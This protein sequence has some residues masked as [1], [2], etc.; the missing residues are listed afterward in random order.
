MSAEAAAS[1]LRTHLRSSLALD[2]SECD[3]EESGQPPATCGNRYVAIRISPVFP[4]D[5]PENAF[6]EVYLA[7]ITVTVRAG[8]V[9]ADYHGTELLH[10]GKPALFQLCRQIATEI[11]NNRYDIMGLMNELLDVNSQP[12]IEP[13]DWEG[14]SQDPEP[15]GPEWFGSSTEDES[16]TDRNPAGYK[17][18]LRFGGLYRIQSSLGVLEAD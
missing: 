10:T 1:A 12:F 4:R 11:H 18:D 8:A 14:S 13:L 9:P 3:I 7:T 16:F 2:A 17:I 15:V 5:Q 6:A